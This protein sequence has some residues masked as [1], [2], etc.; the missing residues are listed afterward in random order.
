M[1]LTAIRLAG[2]KSFA[3]NTVFPVDAPVTGII[4]PNGCGKSNIIDAVR[5]VLGESAAKQ[6]RGQSLTDVI[7]GGA[8]SRRASGMATVALHF[9]NS[10]GAAGGAFAEYGE[11]VVQRRVSSDGESHYSINQQRCRRKDVVELLQG[12]GV[13][14]RS[15][16]VIEQGMVSRIVESKPEELRAFIEEAAGIGVYKSRRKDSEKRMEQTREHLARHDDR[17]EQLA[18][19]RQRLG[20]EAETARIYREYQSEHSELSHRLASWK[21]NRL[22]LQIAHVDKDYQQEE[23]A[24]ADAMIAE[25]QANQAAEAAQQ[26]AQTA[27]QDYDRQRQHREQQQA[28]LRQQEQQLHQQQQ[29]AQHLAQRIAEAQTRLQ[30]FNSQLQADD[31]ETLAWQA[32]SDSK[33]SA[34]KQIEQDIVQYQSSVAEAEQAQQSRHAAYEEARQLHNRL[35]FR[36][37]RAAQRSQEAKARQEKLHERLGQQQQEAGEDE[38]QQFALEENQMAIESLQIA[39]EHS[40]AVYESAQEARASCQAAAANAAAQFSDADKQLQAI[41]HRLQALADWLPQQHNDTDNG[42]EALYQRLTISAQWQTA[43]ERHFAA[44]LNSSIN[45]IP[46]A[47]GILA[48]GSAPA[49][50]QNIINSP[51]ALGALLAHLQPLAQHDAEIAREQLPAGQYFLS[52]DG[53]IIG[54]DAYLPALAHDNQGLMQRLAELQDL[55]ARQEAQEQLLNECGA[56]MDSAEQRLI[57]AREAEKQAQQA[58]STQEKQ[59]QELQHQQQLLR[60]S[61]EHQRNLRAKEAQ[62]RL[63]LQEDIAAAEQVYQ[64]AQQELAEAQRESAHLSDIGSLEQARDQANEALKKA[65]TALR[66]QE[67]LRQQIAQDIHTLQTQIEA[68]SRQQQRLT[69]EIQDNRRQIETWQQEAEELQYLMEEQQLSLEN[70]RL[71][72]EDSEAAYQSALAAWDSSQIALQDAKERQSAGV[73]ARQLAAE[74]LDNRHERLENLENQ[75]QQQLA[76]IQQDDRPIIAFAADEKIDENALNTRIRGLKNAMDKLGAV[77]L[78]AVEAFEQSDS[79]YQ[80]LHQ[81]CEDLRNTLNM[82]TQAIAVL[83]N[84]TRSRLSSTFDSVNAY[85]SEYFPLLFRGGEGKMQWTQGDILEAG[86]SLVVRPPGKKVKNLSVLSGGE[87]AL[88]AVALVFAFFKLNPA[89]FCLLDEI[90]APLDDA[91]V[92]RLCTLLREMSLNTQFIMIT[93][94][95]RSMQSCDRLIGVTMSEPG[96]SR[97]VSVK[98]EDVAEK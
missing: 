52:L 81:Q 72:D 66:E 93:H 31:H 54:Q 43:I 35:Q 58:L 23:Q 48:A 38:E 1:R 18:K 76:A 45:H 19:Q 82:L 28:Q 44:R 78:A 94:H 51:A 96:V 88:T 5:W 89:P 17:L 83:D 16:A 53:S 61:A 39:L 73:H 7:F 21:I 36:I 42:G 30:R 86:I 64:D 26:Q 65:Q 20:Q 69:R 11:I 41:K 22:Q 70:S 90:D 34:L 9:D 29:Q 40:Q 79:E 8:K 4:G 47:E 10:A 6:L 98:F 24:L 68:Q 12:T 32:D 14:A 57:Q 55:E 25:E 91:N 71:I 97:L 2:F 37:E 60:Q 62:A 33:S 46:N 49:A 92:G 56:A 80:S 74:R 87:K 27:R 59:L 84:E 85:F 15:Y 95:K 67:N 75:L 63:A 77:N 13:G 50:W 3:D